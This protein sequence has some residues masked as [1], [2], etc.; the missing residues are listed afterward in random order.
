MN[1]PRHPSTPP[2]ANPQ[3][4]PPVSPRP[5]IQ[6]QPAQQVRPPMAQPVRPMQT[7]GAPAPVARPTQQADDSIA[8]VEDLEEVAVQ[9]SATPIP[10]KIKF[11]PD[12]GHKK[13]DWKR[14][15]HVTGTGACRVKSFHAKY[16]DQG[17]EH[18][19]DQI[20]EW[21]DDHPEIEVKFVSTTVHVFEGKIREPAIVMN[22][23]Y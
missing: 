19:D 5:Q 9:K 12:T 2:L 14:K 21:L 13:H 20:N 15:P 3:S 7:P 16:S 22:V 18:M 17:V 6:P 11:G 10:S 23:W 4:H 8:L 1:D